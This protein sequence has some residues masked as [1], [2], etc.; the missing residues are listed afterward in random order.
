MSDMKIANVLEPMCLESSRYQCALNDVLKTVAFDGEKFCYTTP[1][2]RSSVILSEFRISRTTFLPPHTKAWG[3]F[4]SP[5]CATFSIS[6]PPPPGSYL[7]QKKHKLKWL[8]FQRIRDITLSCNVPM[9][10]GSH[11]KYRNT[12]AIL[13]LAKST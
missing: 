8:A 9:S 12:L 7:K 3:C 11:L 6:S 4:I 1:C 13:S 5:I 10:N 2:H